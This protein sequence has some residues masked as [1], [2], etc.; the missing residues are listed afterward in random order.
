MYFYID[1]IHIDDHYDDDEREREL[2]VWVLG[3]IVMHFMILGFLFSN[4]SLL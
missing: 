3:L 1:K 4:L 2:I